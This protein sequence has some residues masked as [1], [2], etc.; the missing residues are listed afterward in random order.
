MYHKSNYQMCRVNAA[1]HLT[2]YT[3]NFI[4]SVCHPSLI[5][6]SRSCRWV[7][8]QRR[9]FSLCLLSGA[10]KGNLMNNEEKKRRSEG[11]RE[12]KTS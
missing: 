10:L 5:F 7:E 8:V 11:G 2:A 3:F 9:I 1:K 4:I 12:K 6:S